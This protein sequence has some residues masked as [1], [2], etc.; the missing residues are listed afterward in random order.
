LVWCKARCGVNFHKRC[1]DQW[2]QTA[3]DPT[4]PTCR[5]HWKH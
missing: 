3:H 2:L 1:I 5:S 4:C